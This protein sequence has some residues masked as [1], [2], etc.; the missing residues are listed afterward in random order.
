[1]KDSAVVEE[2]DPGLFHRWRNQPD[3]QRM[4]L[5]HFAILLESAIGEPGAPRAA[6]AADAG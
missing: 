3:R 6:V 1:M 4:R 5:D 2:L